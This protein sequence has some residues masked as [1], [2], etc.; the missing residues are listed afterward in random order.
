MSGSLG[1]GISQAAGIALGRKL[2]RETGKVWVFMSDG[3]FQS[4][5]TLEALQAMA[6]HR[7][8]NMGIY[9]DVNGCQCDGPMSTVMNIEPLE[10]RL[11]GFNL[12][13]FRVDGHDIEALAALG[14]LKTDGRPTVILCDTNSSQGLPI[15]RQRAPKFHYVRFTQAAE[16]EAYRE[17]LAQ[18]ELGE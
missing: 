11:E 4:G 13:V 18:M 6:Y 8:D 16:R 3:E 17:V 2:K 1:Q 15:L 9:V 10:K 5:Q 14:R 12:R 7:L